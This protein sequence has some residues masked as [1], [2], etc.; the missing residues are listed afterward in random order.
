MIIP[1]EKIYFCNVCGEHT[2]VTAEKAA[3]NHFDYFFHNETVYSINPD[4]NEHNKYGSVGE[5]IQIDLTELAGDEKIKSFK[6]T[7]TKSMSVNE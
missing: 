2:D 5:Q 1:V 3:K 4:G 6:V 7:K